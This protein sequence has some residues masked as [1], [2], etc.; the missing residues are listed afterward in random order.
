MDPSPL[1]FLSHAGVDS[2]A[3]LRFA[4]QI[5]CRPEARN[6][7]L[8]VWIDSRSLIAGQSWQEQ[9]ERAISRDSTA[10]AVYLTSAGAESWVRLEIHAALDRVIDDRKNNKSYPFVPIIARDLQDLRGL[11][12]FAQQYHGVSL[13]EESSALQKLIALVTNADASEV[14]LVAEPFRGL[15]TFG[16]EDAHLFFGRTEDIRKL[17]DRLRQTNLVLV[18]GD[19]GCGKSSLVRAGLVPAFK[20]GLLS[21]P[22]EPRPDP[23]LWHVVE[24]RPAANPIEGLI[25]ASC[26]AARGIRVNAE[27]LGNAVDR[28]R[29][30]QRGAFRDVLRE[31]AASSAD[32]L[33]V[34]DQ[35]E[36]LWTQ[37]ADAAERDTFINELLDACSSDVRHLRVVATIRR[38]YLFQCESHPALR[39]RL[40]DDSVSGKYNVRRMDDAALR[41][42]IERPL[43]LAGVAD[44]EARR[45]AD[46]ILRDVGD[47]PGDLALVEMALFETWQHRARFERLLDAYIATGRVQG[48]LPRAADAALVVLGEERV[49]L[50]EAVF[51]RLVNESPDGGVTRRLA[52]KAEFFPD[53]WRVAQS[54]ASVECGRL[55]VLTETAD[56]TPQRITSAS[57]EHPGDTR[58]GRGRG[59]STPRVSEPVDEAAELAHEQ[60]ATQWPRYQ[61]WLREASEDKR[62][63]DRLTDRTTRW[64]A[65]G[66]SWRRVAAGLDLTEF[67][68][69]QERRRP[70][71]SPSE[72][73][74][75]L[76]SKARRALV[77]GIFAAMIV[78]ALLVA[79]WLYQ[80]Q[81]RKVVEAQAARI[82][83]RLR[84]DDREL[85]NIDALRELRVAGN[86]VKLR[87]LEMLRFNEGLAQEFCRHPELVTR[88]A[89]GLSQDLRD[90][91]VRRV[92]RDPLPQT[93]HRAKYSV[94][95]LGATLE[96][97]EAVEPLL[98]AMASAAFGDEEQL[99]ALTQ[100]L[101]RLRVELSA[102]QAERGLDAFLKALADPDNPMQLQ[103]LREALVKFVDKLTADQA[104][105]AFEV[106]LQAL[107]ARTVS[108]QREVLDALVGAVG[109]LSTAQK[110]QALEALLSAIAATTDWR[111][112]LL[113]NEALAALRAELTPEQTARAM[114]RLLN[115]I[116]ATTN[117]SELLGLGHGLARLRVEVPSEQAA[118]VVEAFLSAIAVTTDH[119][120]LQFLGEDLA[121]LRVRLTAD[122]TSRAQ[123]RFL[124]AIAATADDVRLNS[125]G[126]V[127]AALRVDVTPDEVPLVVEPLLKAIRGT[128][129][130]LQLAA[131]GQGLEARVAQLPA[132]QAARARELLLEAIATTTKPFRLRALSRGVGGLQDEL[133][134]DEMVRAVK[135]FLKAIA[136]TTDGR[137]MRALSQGL[138]HLRSRLTAGQT[139]QV[140]ER[141]L[142]AMAATS[143]A[144]QTRVLGQSLAEFRIAITSN[145]SARVL[146]ALL[147]AVAVT[148]DAQQLTTFDKRLS[149]L[150]EQLV[151]DQTVLK[152]LLEAIGATT[153]AGQANV[154]GHTI[155]QLVSRLTS[156]Q[157]MAAA[158]SLLD[159]ITAA[160]RPNQVWALINGLSMPHLDLT[161]NQIGG[162][163]EQVLRAIAATTD[164]TQ[165]EM[166]PR[167]LAAFVGKLTPDQAVR[168]LE[169]FLKAIAEASHR[170][171]PFGLSAP[172][173][174]LASFLA[175]LSA[176][177]APRA[178][179]S[180]MK[181]IGTPSADITISTLGEGLA[182]LRVDLTANQANQLFESFLKAIAA[183][184]HPS[185]L[186]ELGLGLAGVIARVQD[187]VIAVA[188][189][190]KA[191][192]NPFTAGET[193]TILMAALHQRF[194]TEIPAFTGPWHFMEWAR[195]HR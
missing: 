137:E 191:L 75:V 89:I 55:I 49:T 183:A 45:L 24:M 18:V 155:G 16:A 130:Q 88:V 189:I 160:T 133:N 2:E 100:A 66:K 175:T 48:A 7:G 20:E 152:Q 177:Q 87:L 80:D 108:H 74:F 23:S 26:D 151:P 40:Q 46:E 104:L 118:P 187:A 166:L 62:S 147:S 36:E 68:R 91:L 79:G 84:L 33:L 114:D 85:R 31:G 167:R 56:Q 54:L 173:Q 92:V 168:A 142:S 1:L 150:I 76:A 122:Q 72:L 193:T 38:D 123:E 161:D 181:L 124:K 93:A 174:A 39:E 60:L 139:A 117:S 65:H 3:A 102:D 159:A 176:D 194:P 83:G 148:T 78:A 41:Q 126:R 67:T 17:I 58:A 51:M 70:W 4:E 138:S 71:L 121:A 64:M 5:E 97:P 15:A 22:Y 10:F 186:R 158:E 106:L 59:S 94:A 37:T 6:C 43:A 86:N 53:Q 110:P 171:A 25:R 164:A 21:D 178:L 61:T 146:R 127:L 116:A 8:K 149:E 9:I 82:S 125:L 28:L 30:R 129:D 165:L 103:V 42:C 157:R 50:A 170:V 52:R 111:Q 180:V 140:L 77:R 99:R 182:R 136:T 192:E 144:G 107:R 13:A 156:T 27:L 119:Y 44:E 81:Q 32:V 141:F 109:R 134:N 145:Q 101:V 131:F 143:D 19:S 153:D 188:A 63:L 95:L 162:A 163:L 47:Q 120:Q 69:L 34:I 115:V 98:R 195:T 112:L 113:L 73:T 132:D 190:R 128:V 184:E 29:A 35:F 14:Q 105:R 179:E 154:L 11:P 135:P 90:R 172:G 96:S 169:A 185:T 57:D 12:L